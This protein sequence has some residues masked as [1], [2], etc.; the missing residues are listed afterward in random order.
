MIKQL[1]KKLYFS[2][3]KYKLKKQ[4]VIIESNVSF[5]KTVFN[6]YNRICANTHI[7]NSTIGSFSYVGWNA[8]LGN[9]EIG[10]FVLLHLLLKSFME[11][12]LQIS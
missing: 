6:K 8:I 5:T 7:D 2:V 10:S 12:I 1:L 4:N 3:K 11:H 9:V